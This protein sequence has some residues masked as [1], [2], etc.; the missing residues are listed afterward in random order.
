MS[1][2]A[3][4]FLHTAEVHVATFDALVRASAPGQQVRHLV[5][6]DLLAEA[7][8]GGGVDEALAGRLDQ[9]L[10][11]LAAAGC[12]RIVCTCSTLGGA[13]EAASA[14]VGVPV[15]RVDRPMAEA[16]LAAGRRILVAACLDST[17]GP[18]LGLLAE[19]ARTAGVRPDVRTLVLADAWRLFETGD[20]AG[21][22]RVLADGIRAGARDAEVILLAQASMAGA[23]RLLADLAVPV[24]SSPEASV[25][26]ALHALKSASES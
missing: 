8:A 5:R 2:A 1:G 7:R 16:A 15:M 25:A 6:P 23:A 24:L 12:A 9:A 21:F 18:T 26:R 17:L 4:G 20:E 3:L 13:A 19:I 22:A 11:E 10:A 14:R